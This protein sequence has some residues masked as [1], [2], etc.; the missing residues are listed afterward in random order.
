MLDSIYH[1]IFKLLR[2]LISAV[3]TLSFFHY[4]SNF[5]LEVITFLQNL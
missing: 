3:K 5:D 4:V 1:M 2:N